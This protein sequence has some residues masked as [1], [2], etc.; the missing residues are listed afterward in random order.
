[1]RLTGA[2][3]NLSA[4]DYFG[5][6]ALMLDEPRHANVIAIGPCK[7][8]SLDRSDF[9]ELLGPLQEVISAQMRIRILRSVPLLARLS[10]RDL[11]RLARAM[12]V[13]QFED[14]EYII[15]EGETGT[16]FYIINDGDAV[17][18][19]QDA[20][21]VI[22]RLTNQDYFG[23]IALVK[24]EPRMADVI[25]NGSVECLV[26]EQV[27]FQR[28]LGKVGDVILEEI[29][30]REASVGIVA[31]E[32]VVEMRY[33]YNDLHHIR[34]LGTGTFGRVKLVQHT[35]TGGV[36]ALKCMQK[37][38]IVQA[39]QERNI[40]NEK[41]ILLECKHPFILELYQTFMNQNQLFMLMEIVQGGELWT[42]IYEKVNLI[43]RTALGGFVESAA[44]FYAGCV[45]SAFQYVHDKGVAYRDLKP[46]NL[47]IDS[48]GFCKII[49]FGFA[50][51]IPFMKDG[52]VCAKS[53]TICGT[54]EYLSPELI[55]SSGH[56]K[57]VDYWALGCLVYEL[58]V[59]QTPFQDDNQREIFRKITN[60]KK[61]LA[62]P[63]GMNPS[64]VD[65]IRRL[66]TP[67]PAFRLGNLSGAVDDIM[68][69]AWF[70]ES[71][72]FAW[73]K[74][75]MKQLTPPYV[76]R[77]RDPLDTSNFDPYAEEDHVPRFNGS[78]AAFASFV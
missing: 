2:P 50:K 35:P 28:M 23:E 39:H 68:N 33:E 20:E 14:E 15:R 38:Q 45:I 71:E 43:R 60:S 4:G 31:E 34:T 7:C 11:D 5:E 48:A 16:R 29:K 55:Q 3:R 44:M 52:K 59:G 9:D 13:Q 37:A 74:L 77:I 78:Q 17:I 6:M 57:S 46:E 70:G 66:L 63:K 67:N 65:L 69:H 73:E 75:N 41:N 25:A 21:G 47:L 64:A 10:D 40:M 56:D 30:R 8:L 51:R 26:L 42:Y 72:S 1:M 18:K 32:A 24:N 19:K 58:L 76:P 53:F 62:F 22:G 54:P 12:R 27:D 49:D 61:H 36:F